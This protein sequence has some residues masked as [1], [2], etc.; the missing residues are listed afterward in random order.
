MGLYDCSDRFLKKALKMRSEEDRVSSNMKIVAPI[1]KLKSEQFKSET[2]NDT[3]QEKAQKLSKIIGVLE[4]KM[5]E[6]DQGKLNRAD[7]VK[8]DIKALLLK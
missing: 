6:A 5:K 2:I 3:F 1:I 7:D 8:I 4:K